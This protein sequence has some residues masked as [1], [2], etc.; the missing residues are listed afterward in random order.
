MLKVGQMCIPAET[1][2]SPSTMT[3]LNSPSKRWAFPLSH[4]LVPWRSD[5][6]HSLGYGTLSKFVEA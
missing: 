1:L 2:L 4:P 3:S 6:K 5:L